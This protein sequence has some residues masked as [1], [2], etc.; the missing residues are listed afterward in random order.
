MPDPMPDPKPD[1][2]PSD[3]RAALP[4]LLLAALVAWQ[5]VEAGGPPP[6][7]G[8]PWGGVGFTAMVLGGA[9]P[10]LGRGT[11]AHRAL[12]MLGYGLGIAGAALYVGTVI[13]S[14]ARGERS[15]WMLVPL[16]ALVLFWVWL[17]RQVP[18]PPS[19]HA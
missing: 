9:L 18:R 1:P 11:G 3:R 17:W 7:A 4:M 2:G 8:S 16:V 10:M 14:V 5:W 12:R 15:A 13:V 19:T 6:M